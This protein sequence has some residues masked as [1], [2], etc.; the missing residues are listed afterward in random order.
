MYLGAIPNFKNNTSNNS[1]M[2]ILI[3][4]TTLTVVMVISIL[5]LCCEKVDQESNTIIGKWEWLYTEGGIVG[6]TYP[7]EETTVIEEYTQDSIFVSRIDGA[8][9]EVTEFHTWGD[10]LW[11]DNSKDRK[12]IARISGDTLTLDDLGFIHVYKRLH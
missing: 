8:V 11:Y 10:T 4:G 5:C 7:Q 2:K 9:S 12:Y 6:R 3:R 1:K